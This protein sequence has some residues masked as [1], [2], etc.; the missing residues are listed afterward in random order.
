[1]CFLLQT[2]KGKY[3]L[4]LQKTSWAHSQIST[5]PEIFLLHFFPPPPPKKETPSQSMLTMASKA[6]SRLI[7]SVVFRPQQQLGYNGED[8]SGDDM[9]SWVHKNASLTISLDVHKYSQGNKCK[10]NQLTYMIFVKKFRNRS[11]WGK[12]IRPKMFILRH[13]LIWDKNALL[14]ERGI[15]PHFTVYFK[16]NFHSKCRNLH[17][18]CMKLSKKCVNNSGSAWIFALLSKKYDTRKKISRPPVAT[19]VKNIMYASW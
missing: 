6:D 13:L 3:P 10:Y 5:S 15:K 19:V 11:F 18:M 14:V 17:L 8:R 16:A 9:S 2:L 7:K 1:M 12:K 4:L